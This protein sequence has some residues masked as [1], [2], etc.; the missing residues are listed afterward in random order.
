MPLLL[1]QSA[2]TLQ[3]EVETRR[4]SPREKA[5]SEQQTSLAWWYLKRSQLDHSVSILTIGRSQAPFPEHPA[6]ETK[7]LGMDQHDAK[8]LVDFPDLMACPDDEAPLISLVLLRNPSE[9]D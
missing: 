5:C 2:S 3:E 9:L 1:Q 4:V 7:D 8:D 6:R